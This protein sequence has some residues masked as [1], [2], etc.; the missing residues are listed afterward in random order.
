MVELLPV[1]YMIRFTYMST[2]LTV[3]RR[4]SWMK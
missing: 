4:A 2:T 3:S 1:I